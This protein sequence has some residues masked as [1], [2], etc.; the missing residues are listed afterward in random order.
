MMRMYRQDEAGNSR[1][2]WS[3]LATLYYDDLDGREPAT[4]TCVGAI[5]LYHRAKRVLE[6]LEANV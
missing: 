5:S 4:F 1:E 3:Y 6:Q 2:T